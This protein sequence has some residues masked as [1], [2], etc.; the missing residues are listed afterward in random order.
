MN[1]VSPSGH[2]HNVH[3]SDE[4]EKHP[5]HSVLK[6]R[7]YQYQGTGEGFGG[8]LEH[9]YTH[10]GNPKEHI[11]LQKVKHANGEV[12]HVWRQYGNKKGGY[13]EGR[14]A[15]GLH[16]AA[17]K[18]EHMANQE[19]GA[20]QITS[21]I[22]TL[23]RKK[24]VE[25][26]EETRKQVAAD[27]FGMQFEDPAQKIQEQ[28]DA[29]YEST[30]QLNEKSEIDHPLAKELADKAVHN[31]EQFHQGNHDARHGGWA[32][33]DLHQW[34]KNYAKKKDKGVYDKE[35]AV[36]GL[37]HAIKRSE[38]SYFGKAH[39][40]KSGQTVSGAT[41]TQAARH[42]LP[43]VE[44]LMPQH[45]KKKVNEAREP[46]K[47]TG[48]HERLKR[49][50]FEYKGT[51]NGFRTYTQGEHEVKHKFPTLNGN[52]SFKHTKG[53][54]T[55]M[56]S[57]NTG[58]TEIQDHLDKH[59]P[60]ASRSSKWKGVDEAV[61]HED[62]WK[63]DAE[64]VLKNHGF[65]FQHK[66]DMPAGKGSA[67]RYLHPLSGHNVVIH[68]SG[69]WSTSAGPHASKGQGSEELEKHLNTHHKKLSEASAAM[70]R[71]STQHQAA[72][73]A[74]WSKA[75]DTEKKKL[76][77]HAW[78]HG[79]D[80]PDW[81]DNQSHNKSPIHSFANEAEKE[82]HATMKPAAEKTKE[83]KKADWKNDVRMPWPKP[84]SK[85]KSPIHTFAEHV[86]QEGK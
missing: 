20:F 3:D 74:R 26:I 23:L 49:H 53:P 2:S 16:H 68:R 84:E 45:Q 59:F 77:K 9:H 7:G 39:H 54:K 14:N 72:F 57:A 21:A 50:G 60:I 76:K 32:M 66:L 35:K 36:K 56:H 28:I 6:K 86:R 33:H 29:A 37:T 1:F 31:H 4:A 70:A 30:D 42:L 25:A 78:D 64:K 85:G 48:V 67:K 34:A 10:A 55:V 44:K 43:H 52:H 69:H 40:E 73:N 63:V 81:N 71:P 46:Q 58:D 51:K 62:K 13:R 82:H 17:V 41:R 5:G 15:E 27:A 11:V 19:N 79:Y 80:I 47:N 61:L 24:T 8:N 22:E 12:E 38:P 75:D 65:D 18:E 83:Q